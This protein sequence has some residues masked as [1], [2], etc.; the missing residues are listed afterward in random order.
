MLPDDW[1][2]DAGP[3]LLELPEEL[4]ALFDL[5]HHRLGGGP[6]FR[7]VLGNAIACGA[8]QVLVERG[9]IDADYR[10]EFANFYA[11]TFRPLPDRCHRLHFLNSEERRYCGYS[12]M[13]PIMGRPVSRTLLAAT[14]N[15]RP[16]I[17]CLAESRAYPYGA[18]F[19]VESFP[20]IS[21]DYQYGRC[22][23]A[24]IWMVALYFHLRF[25]RARFHIS[26][27]VEAARQPSQAFR[28]TPSSGLTHPQITAALEALRMP[29]ISYNLDE[30]PR[31]ETPES[32]ACRYLNSRLP[33]IVLGGEHA[34][35]LLGYGVEAKNRLFFICNDDARGPYRP[36]QDSGFSALRRQRDHT[37]ERLVV[38]MPG[39]IYL[40]GE[41][42][43]K[44]GGFALEREL[45]RHDDL[46]S[47]HRANL[48][49]KYRRRTYVTTSAK[50]RQG[51]RNRGLSNDVIQW[52]SRC[53][54]SHWV[55]V[56]ELQDR[57]AAALG[58]RCVIGEIVID[59]TSDD[60]APNFFSA[61]LP[62]YLKRW[63][64]LGGET[65]TETSSHRDLY[66]SGCALHVGS[67]SPPRRSLG[68]RLRLR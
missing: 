27:I 36:V 24:A 11:E 2:E 6:V 61:N 64:E 32:V 4:K 13:R 18:S 49:G 38:P 54:A 59:A 23:H 53:N 51:L 44:E 1:S 15:L 40:A 29:P 48:N 7:Q 33:V 26:D 17:A 47:Y 20:F 42:A 67:T 30:L 9:Y 21:Q 56:I 5:Y 55:W 68:E 57:K 14:P 65:Q 22:A 12:V 10:S 60:R 63:N 39:R 43:E 35:V 46:R 58:N 25:D 3:R 45:G 66:Q 19:S 28:Q 34:R 52:H 41:A 31:N 50:Y 37:W 8:N 62:G 16:H